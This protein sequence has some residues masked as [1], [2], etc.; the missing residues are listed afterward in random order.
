MG[1]KE[2]SGVY[3]VAARKCSSVTDMVP[4]P[5]HHDAHE[6]GCWPSTPLSRWERIK[7]SDKKSANNREEGSEGQTAEVADQ[8]T[9]D[10]PAENGESSL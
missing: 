6:Q 9:T 5:C 4:T 3:V 7:A 2:L 10:L 8:Q 1:K